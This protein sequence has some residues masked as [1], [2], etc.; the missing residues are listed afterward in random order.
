MILI[1]KQARKKDS[2]NI[3]SLKLYTIRPEIPF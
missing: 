3:E 2:G 1:F